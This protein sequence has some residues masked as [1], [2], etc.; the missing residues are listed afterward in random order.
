MIRDFW[1]RVIRN[2]NFMALGLLIPPIWLWQHP[3]LVQ[4]IGAFQDLHVPVIGWQIL[5]V[6]VAI[7]QLVAV[8][9]DYPPVR[10]PRRPRV[11]AALASAFC[12]I[13]LAIAFVGTSTRPIIAGYSL[14]FALWSIGLCI[15]HRLSE[16]V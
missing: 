8:W 12:Y 13:A 2:E 16:E 11:W 3:E 5:F 7:W 9:R 4:S 1:K 15:N 14:L 6:S 10:K